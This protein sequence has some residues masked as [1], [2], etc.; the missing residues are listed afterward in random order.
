MVKDYIFEGFYNRKHLNVFQ[1]QFPKLMPNTT[2][3][4]PTIVVAIA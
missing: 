2:G 4:H 1:I 3:R